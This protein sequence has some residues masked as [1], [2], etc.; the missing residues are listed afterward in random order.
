ML[1]GL[2]ITLKFIKLFESASSFNLYLYIIND[3]FTYSCI[4]LL[5]SDF[6]IFYNLS[7][8][9][10]SVIESFILENTDKNTENMRFEL[11]NELQKKLS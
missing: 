3:L 10:I 7:L 5:D 6:L 4:F 8:C 9:L 1:L 11:V 2:S